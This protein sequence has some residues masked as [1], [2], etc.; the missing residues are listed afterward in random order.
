M[1]K[2]KGLFLHDVRGWPKRLYIS[3]HFPLRSVKSCYPFTGS[4]E[5]RDYVVYST[6]KAL[7][8][9]VQLIWLEIYISVLHLKFKAVFIKKQKKR[10]GYVLCLMSLSY[11]DNKSNSVVYNRNRKKL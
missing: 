11:M 10:L 1:L 8:L 6:L 2:K 5:R 9:N 7:I 3:V 4:L